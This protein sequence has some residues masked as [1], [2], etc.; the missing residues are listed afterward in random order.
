M[1][2]FITF[3][4]NM[5]F[6]MI[7]FFR[8]GG[9]LLF[10]P[11][12]GHTNIPLQVRIAIALMFTLVLYSTLHTN[13]PPLPSTIMPYLAIAVKEIA[14]GAVVGFAASI[15]FA[16]ITMAGNLITNTIGLDTATVV[17]PSSEMGEEEQV[18]TV[19]LNMLAVLIFLAIDGHH[20]FIKT[21]AQSFEVIPVGGFHCTTVTLAKIMAIFE[22]LFVIGIKMSAPSL[23]ALLLTVVVLGFMTKV[24]QEINVFGIAFQVKILIGFFILVISMPLIISLMEKH[25]LTLEKGMASLLSTM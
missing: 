10:A 20:W 22:S 3:V 21:T 24:A 23:V 19:F 12:F 25:L 18:I 14:I 7:V 15:I 2:Y 1:E 16:A 11:I 5:P 9:M 6:F 8:V 13:Q 17:D 4:N